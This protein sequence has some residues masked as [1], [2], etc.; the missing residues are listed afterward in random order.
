MFRAKINV[1]GYHILH[2]NVVNSS[3]LLTN[4]TA[5]ELK[6]KY[7]KFFKDRG[8]EV[9]PSASLIPENDPTALFIS[10]GM[11]PLVPYFLGEKH[12]SG[13]R[14]VNFQK[15]IRTG[16]IDE[17]G[18]GTHLTFFEM[19]GNWSLG[20]YWKEESISWS[21]EFLTKELEI[22]V[23]KLGVSCFEGDESTSKD[24][25]SAKIWESLDIPK[26]RIFFLGKEDNWW[27]PAGETGPCGPDTEIFYWTGEGVPPPLTSANNSEGWVEI[28]NNVFMEY[29]KTIDGKYVPLNQ[30]NVDT[31]MGVERTVA[32]LSGKSSVYNTE[33]FGPIV[34]K[35]KDF[36]GKQNEKPVRVIADHIRAATFILGDQKCIPPSNV[37]Q[38]YVLRKLI[39]RA[40]RYG[41]LLGISK[42]FLVDFS[43]VVV[44]NH[45]DD[46]PELLENQNFIEKYLK[47]EEEKF[48][49]TLEKG[50]EE[51]EKISAND[52][53]GK[54]AF[55]LFSSFGFPLEMTVDLAQEKG[56]NVDTKGFEEEFKK[57]Q[58]LSR[59][60]SGER[61]KG[62]LADDSEVVTAYH[63]ATHLLQ[64]ALQE[65]LGDHVH[66][67]GSNI[68]SERLRFD[69]THESKLAEEKIVK[70]ENVINKIIDQE[71]PVSFEVLSQEEAIKAGAGYLEGEKYPDKVKVY[72]IGESLEL[73]ISKEFCGGPHVKNT[74]E[75]KHV[76]IYKQKGM[77]EGKVRIYARFGD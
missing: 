50:L 32:I 57:H 63:T 38:G 24:K 77:G 33:I 45:L 25:E 9:I 36:S 39:R 55:L 62:G 43:K 69:F 73:A 11:H 58:E 26:E 72:F 1:A 30:K 8:H 28:W 5:K 31:G 6:E 16:D 27:G 17:V 13:N 66:Q 48:S 52:I 34:K 20:D 76:E 46:Y 74:S 41:K 47:L 21:F 10:A 18:D 51:F 68:T 35:I 60:G 70:V 61:F 56:L 44:E 42:P 49:K 71:L 75:L 59:A 2:S 22:P 65:V 23:E 53:S 40:I 15:C 67:V 54:D 64:V 29:N 7:L 37:G 4:M 3:E 19:L 12:P 14:L